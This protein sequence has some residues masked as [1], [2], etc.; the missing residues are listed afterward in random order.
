[1]LKVGAP[2]PLFT[3]TSA[4]GQ[5][6]SL[7]SLRGRIVVLY[8]FRKAF[9]R[10][11][12]VE[13]KGFRDNYDDL[14]T[15]GAEVIGVSLDDTPTQ[16]SFAQSLGVKFPMIADRGRELA[17][18]YKVFFSFLPLVHRVTY[19]IDCDGIIAGVFNHELQVVKHLD[20]VMQFVRRLPPAP[21]AAHG[22]KQ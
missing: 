9:T 6:V 7:E 10:N 8:F 15:L 3:A 17:H 14:T 1:M 22:S 5:P 12:T 16:C 11:C 4:T 19:V 20:Q 18:A 13:T 21:A 2:A